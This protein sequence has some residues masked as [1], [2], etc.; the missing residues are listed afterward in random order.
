[1]TALATIT[2]QARGG[3]GSKV[4]KAFV[5]TLNGTDTSITA[6]S[7]D[8][9]Y[10]DSAQITAVSI[11]SGIAPYLTVGCGPLIQLGKTHANGDQ[12]NLWVWGS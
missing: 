5:V 7:L 11:A 6:D 3:V 8:M 12:I 2:E 1:M 10:I 4:F 9:H